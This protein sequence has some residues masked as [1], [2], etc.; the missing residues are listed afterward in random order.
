[1][2]KLT[3]QIIACILGIFIV[4]VPIIGVEFL[5][6]CTL[7]DELERYDKMKS[8]LVNGTVTNIELAE[9]ELMLEIDDKKIILSDL[10]FYYYYIPYDQSRIY[11]LIDIGDYV[12]ISQVFIKV[13]NQTIYELT[14]S[15]YSQAFIVRSLYIIV[16]AFWAPVLHCIYS[17]V[18]SLESWKDIALHYKSKAD[19]ECPHC[20]RKDI[21]KYCQGCGERL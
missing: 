13:N 8:V 9:E 4:I 17:S 14:F 16:V 11:L 21:S 7:E 1:M 3:G 2:K 10:L 20:G 5:Y 18:Q 6:N 12:E 15:S 19:L